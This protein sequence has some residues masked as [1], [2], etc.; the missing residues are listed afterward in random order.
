MMKQT[1]PPLKETDAGYSVLP[2][3]D[4]VRKHGESV[5]EALVRLAVAEALRR[6]QFCQK[7]ASLVLGCTT[8]ELNYWC[9]KYG[10]RPKDTNG[11]TGE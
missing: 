6:S 2:A 8:R 9:Q 11:D 4:A 1:V 3:A 10:W 7:T 5:P